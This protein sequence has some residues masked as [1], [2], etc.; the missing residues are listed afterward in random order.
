MYLLD[1]SIIYLWDI[2]YYIFLFFFTDY[3]LS[4][5][6]FDNDAEPLCGQW[7]NHGD[8]DYVRISGPTPT[9]DTGPPHDHT[10]GYGKCKYDINQ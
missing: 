7:M 3:I 10:S 9:E 8:V 4:T 1:I 5:C 2:C 6:D